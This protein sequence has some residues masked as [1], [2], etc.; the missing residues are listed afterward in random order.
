M[1]TLYVEEEGRFQ[2]RE[3]RRNAV[4]RK[5]NTNK[6]YQE[7]INHDEHLNCANAQY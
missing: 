2:P 5:K 3:N 1:E 6:E 4:P 7:R